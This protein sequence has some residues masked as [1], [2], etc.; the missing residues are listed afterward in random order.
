[1]AIKKGTITVP[2]KPANLP[3]SRTKT[4]TG[5]T[6][7]VYKRGPGLNSKKPVGGR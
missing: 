4:V 6:Q 2:P 1:M 7:S 3:R 5:A